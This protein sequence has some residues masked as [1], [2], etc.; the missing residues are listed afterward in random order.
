[1][2]TVGGSMQHDHIINGH[3]SIIAFTGFSFRPNSAGFDVEGLIK[4]SSLRLTLDKGI[5]SLLFIVETEQL[6]STKDFLNRSL[7]HI[8]RDALHPYLGEEM[9]HLVH[10][11]K[12][13]AT[14]NQDWY[15]EEVRLHF[16]QAFNHKKQVYLVQRLMAALQRILPFTFQKLE[17][18]PESE[19]DASAAE[20]CTFFLEKD[21]NPIRRLLCKWFNARKKTS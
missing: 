1:M 3:K 13:F 2:E 15:F 16:E 9:V 5:L 19:G 10:V 20:E 7:R 14:E 8:S 12:D 18:W 6:Q 4:F 17:W 21:S 11:P